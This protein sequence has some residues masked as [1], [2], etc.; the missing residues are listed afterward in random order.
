MTDQVSKWRRQRFAGY[1]DDFLDWSWH[2]A[3]YFSQRDYDKDKQ[4]NIAI[5]CFIG[6]A[7]N[8]WNQF[9]DDRWYRHRSSVKTWVQLLLISTHGVIRRLS[10]IDRDHDR[11]S[12]P[13]PTS[14]RLHAHLSVVRSVPQF[15]SLGLTL[16][17]QFHRLCSPMCHRLSLSRL[18]SQLVM[19]SRV[20]TLRRFSRVIL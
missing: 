4:F 13:S 10:N 9:E 6:Y 2:M 15:E 11:W 17:S 18:T 19:Y 1:D 20:L 8:W 12:P 3:Y 5:S 14:C 16:V 7:R